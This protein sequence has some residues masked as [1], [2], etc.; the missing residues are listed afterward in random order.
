MSKGKMERLNVSILSVSH[1]VF[2][3]NTY[4]KASQLLNANRN[5][6]IRRDVITHQVF[7]AFGLIHV[8]EVR[9]I[10][11]SADVLEDCNSMAQAAA[12]ITDPGRN[13]QSCAHHLVHNLSV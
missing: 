8:W 4:R 12:F 13:K 2:F 1:Y 3:K 10:R 7:H 11:T 5:T 6:A 9:P